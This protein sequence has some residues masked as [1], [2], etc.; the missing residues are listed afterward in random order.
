[1]ETLEGQTDQPASLSKN[2]GWIPALLIIGCS[3]SSTVAIYGVTTDLLQFLAQE[4]NI[5]SIRASQITNIINSLMNLTPVAGAVLCDSYLGC[6]STIAIFT[7]ISSLVCT[8]SNL[9]PAFSL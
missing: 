3:V 1:M 4:F 8:P 7:L 6:F 5:N 9:P 2:G